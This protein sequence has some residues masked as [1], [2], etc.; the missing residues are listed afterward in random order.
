MNSSLLPSPE[1]KIK[2]KLDVIIKTQN[3]EFC[4][5]L[6]AVRMILGN[7]LQSRSIVI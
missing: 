4:K 2:N 6:A 3:T 1:K 5:C 7:R